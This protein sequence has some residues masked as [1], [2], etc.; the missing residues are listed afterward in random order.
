MP[1]ASQ[2]T[3]EENLLEL[4]ITQKLQNTLEARG[5]FVITNI[6]HEVIEQ[7]GNALIGQAAK[8]PT[9]TLD[10]VIASDGGSA[11]AVM[12]LHD[13]LRTLPSTFTIRGIACGE[14]GS[15]A[16]AL[17]QLCTTRCSLPNCG[18]FIHHLQ[19]ELPLIMDGTEEIQAMQA[20]STG[21]K[22]QAN[23]IALQCKRT[24]IT[25]RVWKKLA[26]EGQNY[27]TWHTANE[28]KELNLIDEIIASYPLI[29]QAP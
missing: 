4:V 24:G 28:A 6:T 1:K 8:N 18:F 26:N 19:Y 22:I 16:L 7:L 25:P 13:I 9:G 21:K 5:V 10:M 12:V 15:A 29:A 2:S 27:H 3:L 11:T 23:M 20:I 14:C 17:L